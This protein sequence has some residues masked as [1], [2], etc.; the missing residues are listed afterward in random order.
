M[1]DGSTPTYAPYI[2]NIVDTSKAIAHD[3]CLDDTLNLIITVAAN[4]TPIK[5]C[6]LWLLDESEKPPILRLKVTSSINADYIQTRTLQINE[7]VVGCAVARKRL[8]VVDNV[9]SAP[10]FKEKTMARKLGL[11]SML[12]VPLIGYDGGVLGALSCFTT[13]P[14]RFSKEEKEVITA[15]ADQAAVVIQNTELLVRNRLV[16]EELHTH[17][18][19][20]KAADVLIRRREINAAEATGCIQKYSNDS[21]QSIRYIAEAILLSD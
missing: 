12:G 19:L 1:Q 9:L 13:Y 14:H 16:Q 5:I 17:E 7:G 20:K 10:R 15:V 6:S 3:C 2:Q 4:V 8:L 18:L 11:V 21:Y